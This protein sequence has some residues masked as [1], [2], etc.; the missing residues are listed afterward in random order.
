MIVG[1]I[2]T[3]IDPT[4][5]STISHVADA[6]KLWESLRLRFSI[7]N[8]VRKHLVEDEITN[9]KQNGMT[10]FDYLGRL[11]KLWEEQQTFKTITPCTCA[12]AT[13]LEKERKDAKI[14]KFLFGLDDSRF[15]VIRS[16]II[17]ED[18]LPHLKVV[19][20]RVIRAEQHLN[21][22]C[23]TEIKQDAIGFS[24]KIE[25]A[26]SLPS[27]QV[28]PS[29]T[30]RNCDRSCTHC[31][32]TSH[33]T[34]ECFLLH[35]FP[36]WYLEQQQQ[37]SASRGSTGSSNRGRRGRNSNSLG[38]GR[39]RSNSAFAA[40][41]SALPTDQIATL[42]NLLQSQQTQ[43]SSERLSGIPNTSDVIIDIGASHHMTGD[44]SL[45]R[46]VVSITP[47]AVTFLM[48]LLL[49]LQRWELYKDGNFVV[50]QRLLS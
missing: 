41:T 27:S 21:N 24:A 36:D 30:F 2:R 6:S 46:D 16:Q 48:A 44:F 37:R 4:V 13:E 33:D 40:T 10:V 47:F 3:S 38:R 20:S 1:W 5:R 18:P 14:H 26:S 8:S 35:G 43:L 11:S 39:G 7:K 12:V 25:S 49:E 29:S 28:T 17:D 31:K 34:S 15:S 22:M 9:C 45:L 42:I 32:R 19:Y 50:E 23:T